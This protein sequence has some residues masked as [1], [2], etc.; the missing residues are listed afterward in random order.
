[1][2]SGS[3]AGFAAVLLTGTGGAP[4]QQKHQTFG[5]YLGL[6][7]TGPPASLSEL[8]NVK[9][10]SRFSLVGSWRPLEKVAFEAKDIWRRGQ[11]PLGSELA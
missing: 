2:P 6:R 7:L 5:W 1:M 11:P 3:A 8:A 9:H 10:R 4:G